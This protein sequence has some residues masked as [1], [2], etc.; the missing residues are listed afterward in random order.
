MAGMHA[1]D[2]RSEERLKGLMAKAAGARASSSALWG[3]HTAVPGI[4]VTPK[5]VRA[6]SPNRKPTAM[7]RVNAG[8][9]RRWERPD[10]SHG[11]GC[12]RTA[13]CGHLDLWQQQASPDY[14]NEIGRISQRDCCTS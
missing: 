2:V 6:S 7:D 12:R 10:K 4:S 11:C 13:S 1:F 9:V 14:R 5:H 8:D 3:Y